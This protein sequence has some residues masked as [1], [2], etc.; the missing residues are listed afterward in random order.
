MCQ[1]FR[2][3]SDEGVEFSH[4]FGPGMGNPEPKYDSST[5]VVPKGGVLIQGS[6]Y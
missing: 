2:S 3:L 6:L 1:I 5:V 4:F